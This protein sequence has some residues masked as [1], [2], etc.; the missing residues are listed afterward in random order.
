MLIHVSKRGPYLTLIC[1]DMSYWVLSIQ[2]IKMWSPCI[3]CTYV[4]VYK[5]IHIYTV[6]SLLRPK[7]FA[8]TRILLIG[9]ALS[10]DMTIRSI[11]YTGL[12]RIALQYTFTTSISSYVSFMLWLIVPFQQELFNMWPCRYPMI[13]IQFPMIWLHDARRGPLRKTD[14]LKNKQSANTWLVT[15]ATDV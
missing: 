6:V 1:F 4:Y 12:Y 2:E 8:H 10:V 15:R 7:H 11:T 9:M 13:M 5:H 14:S 3:H